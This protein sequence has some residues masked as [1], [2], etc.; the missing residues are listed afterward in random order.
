[1]D[2]GGWARQ[3]RCRGVAPSLLAQLMVG[4][5]CEHRSSTT[6]VCECDA[7]RCSGVSP[8][9][10]YEGPMVVI[11]CQ[12]ISPEV[13][14]PLASWPREIRCSCDWSVAHPERR[15][16]KTYCYVQTTMLGCNME[17]RVALVRKVRILEES[18]VVPQN[19]FEQDQV[20]LSNRPPHTSS[21]INPKR[22]SVRK[23]IHGV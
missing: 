17:R 16:R 18:W 6:S 12:L 13:A 14:G 8:S 11:E 5:N 22:A 15:S 21:N 23:K 10:L 1:M 20:V 9:V 4:G 19:P 2:G 3:A 7:A